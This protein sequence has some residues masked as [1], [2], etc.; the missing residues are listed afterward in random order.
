MRPQL[1]LLRRV[2]EG[3]LSLL[4]PDA[5]AGCEAPLPPFTVFCAPCARTL[6]PVEHTRPGE[7]AAFAY[8]GALADAITSF[9]YSDRP[10]LARP[11]AHL[12]VRAAAPLRGDA[13]T[14]V[15]PVPLHPRRL[16]QRG[17]NQSALL[18]APVARALGARFAPGVLVRVHETTAQAG[19]GRDERLRNLEGAFVAR[20]DLENPAARARV[21]LI[22]DVRTTGATLAACVSA[23][24]AAGAAD[25]R[26]LV[27]AAVDDAP[28]PLRR[29]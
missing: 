2:L 11:L 18:A 17:Y 20:L 4:A 1:P 28:S 26:T 12:L 14:V 3:L 16:A 24:R 6:L 22:D 13:P 5:C 25:V 27:L 10:D 23:L 21:L 9:K 15:V 19:L 7:I 8:G 29:S